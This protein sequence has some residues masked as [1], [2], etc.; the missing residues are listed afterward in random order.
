M[1][2]RESAY[3]AAFKLHNE[4]VWS[5]FIYERYALALKLKFRVGSIIGYR[6]T[7]KIDPSTRN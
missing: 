5:F 3:E 4:T 6:V 1:A 2:G 7:F